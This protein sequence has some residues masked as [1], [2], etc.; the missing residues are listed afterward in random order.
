MHEAASGDGSSASPATGPGN[1]GRGE[2][3]YDVADD[4]TGVVVAL[5]GEL[6]LA[7]APGLQREL[8]TFL[9][10]PVPSLTLDLGGLTFLDSS[11]LGSLYRTRL[12]A[13]DHGV[14]LRLEAVPDHVMRVLDVT[15]MTP[16]F[17]LSTLGS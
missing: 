17:D 2:F 13:D 8:L 6:D 16:L 14:P 5:R 4:A 3:G 7:A 1:L 11:G 9:E 15:A 12:A 10:R